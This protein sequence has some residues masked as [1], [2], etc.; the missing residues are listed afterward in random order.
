MMPVPK[1]ALLPLLLFIFGLGETSKVVVIGIA[2]F[3]QL[4]LTTL[5]GV[6]TIDPVLIQAAQNYG[7]KGWQLFVKVILP[8]ALPSIFTGLRIALSI[9]LL[10]I[11]AAEM[12]AAKRGIGYLIW[13]SW[14]NLSV[15]K[16]YVGIMVMA[17]I[18]LLVTNGLKRLGRWL[19]PWAVDIQERTR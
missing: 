3:F 15:R 2:G 9:S 4:L 19:M 14:S 16:M 1:M 5:H 10:L 6:R 13:L 18:G 12:V 11:V 17:I 8:A 7:A